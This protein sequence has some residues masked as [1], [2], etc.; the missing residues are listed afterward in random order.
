MLEINRFK[1][2]GRYAFTEGELWMASSLCE[3]GFR[4]KGASFLTFALQPADAPLRD[5]GERAP[6]PGR[7]SFRAGGKHFRSGGGAG[8]GARDPADQAFGMHPESLR[9]H[10]SADGR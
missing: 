2:Q 7:A 6:G 8:R 9:P 10:G 1:L 4:L 5:P 3:V